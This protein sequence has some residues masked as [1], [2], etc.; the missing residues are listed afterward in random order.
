MSV[1]AALRSLGMQLSTRS[2]SDRLSFRSR[3]M[4]PKHFRKTLKRATEAAWLLW[5]LSVESSTIESG[6][7]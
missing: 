3:I 7:V 2:L 4:N 1:G 6:S 5:E